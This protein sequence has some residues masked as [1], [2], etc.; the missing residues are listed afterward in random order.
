MHRS[1]ILAEVGCRVNRVHNLP[2]DSLA[3]KFVTARFDI[4]DYKKVFVQWSLR[5]ILLEEAKANYRRHSTVSQ[6]EKFSIWIQQ[7]YRLG[8]D[9]LPVVSP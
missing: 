3:Y 4:I 1:Q 2:R 5:L 9:K 8:L 6:I 7:S